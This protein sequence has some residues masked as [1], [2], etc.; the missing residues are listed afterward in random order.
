VISRTRIAPTP[1]GF[2][3][4]GNALN[5]L[6]TQAL[7]G[8]VGA[9]LRLRIDD[10]DQERVR[11]EY[12]E[13]VFDT[14]HWLGITWQEGPADA[15]DHAAHHGQRLRLAAYG[16]LLSRLKDRGVLYACSCTRAQAVVQGS[17][18]R[19]GANCVAGTV[20][21]DDPAANW[22]LRVPMD[23]R[24][25]LLDWSGTRSEVDVY[26]AIGHPVLL[27]RGVDGRPPRP[28][29]QVASLS[30][31]LAHGTTH[32]VRGMDLLASSA[33]QWYMAAVL[34]EQ[35]FLGIRF[36]HHALLHDDHGVKLSKSA[37]AGSLRTQRMAGAGPGMFGSRLV[38]LLEQVP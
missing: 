33:C 36:H 11:P 20:A 38:R 37:G 28:A 19:C 15:S 24:A 8:R 14:M 25:S 6:L 3:H 21:F 32:V 12:V 26:A 27:Q 23:A 30:D 4:A 5:F 29:Y 34:D 22:R 31:D 17:G 2:L 10:L 7:A 9:R 18:S 1:S 16:A 35:A 13:D